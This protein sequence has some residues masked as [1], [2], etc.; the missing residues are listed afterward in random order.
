ML[1]FQKSEGDPSDF[2]EN[3][4]GDPSDLEV[5]W[6]YTNMP[7]VNRSIF[8]SCSYL[9]FPV[10]SEKSGDKQSNTQPHGTILYIYIYIDI[11]DMPDIA[12]IVVI[13]NIVDIAGMANIAYIADISDMSDI[14][15]IQ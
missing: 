7:R 11:A 6:P 15:D 2:D 5:F 3:P 10:V 14:A 12:D 13:A 1:K 9:I 8:C 4:K